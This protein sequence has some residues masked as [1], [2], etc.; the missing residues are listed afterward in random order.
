MRR[1]LPPTLDHQPSV[2]AGPIG[3]SQRHG[4]APL[5]AATAASTADRAA[6]PARRMELLPKR[7]PRYRHQYQT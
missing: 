7:Q 3:T 1:Q 6:I 2:A 4:T 5:A